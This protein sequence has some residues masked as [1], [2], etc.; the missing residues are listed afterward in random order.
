MKYTDSQR[1]GR[2]EAVVLDDPKLNQA[3]EWAINQ[4]YQSVAAQYAKT[5][6]K[7]IKRIR[8]IC[9]TEE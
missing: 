5:L 8:E 6:A 2:I 4:E 9:E 1:M 7:A 3:F